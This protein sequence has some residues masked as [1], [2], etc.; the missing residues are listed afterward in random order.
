MML[1]EHAPKDPCMPDPTAIV[2]QPA[3]LRCAEELAALALWDQDRD[4]PQGWHLSPRAVETFVLGTDGEAL[5]TPDG[6]SVVVE[7]KFFGHDTLVQR[8]IVTLASDRGLL[9]IGEP[10]T[11]KSWLS[12]HLAAAISGTSA[13]T[14]QGSAGLTEDQIKYSWNYAM[15]LAQGPTPEALVPAPLYTGMVQGRVV[16]FEEITRAPHE[17]Q[18]TLLMALSDKV[19]VVPEL[20]GDAGVV[21]ARRGFAL[22][23]TA[24]TRDRGINE[25]SAALKRRFN[26]E[27]VPPIDDLQ[28]EMKVVRSQVDE[29]V[30]SATGTPVQLDDD[31]LELLVTTFH[32]I[33]SG[34]T[35]DGVKVDRASTVM[36]TAEAVS[37]GLHSALHASFFADGQ[38]QPEHLVQHLIGTA[39]KDQPENLEVLRRYFEVA[40]KPRARREVGRWPA[41]WK[42]RALLEA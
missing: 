29:A 18:D 16:R 34:H 27:T 15:L 3:E 28:Q 5:P 17:V 40:V 31:V 38:V 36:S 33:R 19:V 32:E 9:L 12:E 41:Y 23:A 39:V 6:G 22:I 21:R 30:A 24:N 4:K 26:F 37:V 20:P 8:S 25:M 1:F 42:A 2:R 14:I 35:T 7:R 11:A 13:L 10:G